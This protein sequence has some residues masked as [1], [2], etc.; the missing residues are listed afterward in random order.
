MYENFTA[1]SLANPG[2][3]MYNPKYEIHTFNYFMLGD[4]VGMLPCPRKRHGY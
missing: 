2:D 1:I 3:F 4:P